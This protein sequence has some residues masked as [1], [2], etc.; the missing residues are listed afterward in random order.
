MLKPG[1]LE[2][3]VLTLDVEIPGDEREG[4]DMFKAKEIMTTDVI[5]VTRRTDIYEAIR[6]MVRNNVTGLPVV[7]DDMSLA[8]IITEKDVL[9]LL[10]NIQDRPGTVEDF[11]TRDPVSFDENE[12][13][14]DIAECFIENNFRRVPILTG[15]KLAGIVSRKD[16]IAYILKLRHKDKVAV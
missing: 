3:D 14:I 10:Y 8:G 12:S 4:N 7:N 16:I 1:W 2:P 11:M 6:I 5:T 15:G 9:S 13:L